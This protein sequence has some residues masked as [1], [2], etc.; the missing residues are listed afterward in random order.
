MVESDEYA[1]DEIVE[2]LQKRPYYANQLETHRTLPA[3]TAST[4]ELDF[5]VD[6]R[7]GQ[8][9]TKQ[10]VT[11]LYDHQTAA[12]EAVRDGKNVVLATPTASGKS[13]AYTIP[14]FERALTAGKT[15]L[16]IA[17]QVALI[18]DQEETLSEL[19]HGLGFGTPVSVAQYT[20][21]LSK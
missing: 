3:R 15:A 18:N 1:V 12:I 8:A 20:G 6:S 10:G 11:A 9:L 7:L 4:S 14:A 2:W 5:D 13:L 19:A 16:Y 17:P 21:R